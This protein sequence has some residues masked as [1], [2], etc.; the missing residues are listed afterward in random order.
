MTLFIFCIGGY[1]MALLIIILGI[2]VTLAAL[3]S[4]Y[5]NDKKMNGTMIELEKYEGEIRNLKREAELV[6]RDFKNLSE[7]K[8]TEL[9]NKIKDVNRAGTLVE[10]KIKE[11]K[12]IVTILE[13]TIAKSE[14]IEL[15]DNRG[16]T[17]FTKSKIIE[18][19]KN[20]MSIREISAKSGKTF[21]DLKH[22]MEL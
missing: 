13:N 3:V 21:E 19:Y 12:S 11:G 6:L 22:I 8:M 18:L 2:A 4:S 15:D 1:E 7:E 10:S 20:G 5:F 9:N 17:E 16:K 14:E